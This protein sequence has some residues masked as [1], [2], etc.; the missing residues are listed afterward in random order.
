MRRAAKIGL[1]AVGSIA[2]IGVTAAGTI[3]GVSSSRLNRTFPLPERTTLSVPI[4]Q[5]DLVRGEHLVRSVSGCADCHGEDLGGKL[6]MDAGPIG[7]ASGSNLT[8]GRGGV[9]STFTDEDWV[10]AIRHGL[11]RDGRSLLI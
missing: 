4:A 7:V 10:L 3:Y 11:R 6:F 1:I 8:A 2:F 9:A 5:G